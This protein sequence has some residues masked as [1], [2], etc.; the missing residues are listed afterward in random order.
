MSA[1]VTAG[2]EPPPQKLQILC[3]YQG[4]ARMDQFDSQTALGMNSIALSYSLNPRV[5]SPRCFLGLPRLPFLTHTPAS[6]GDAGQN[7]G[8]EKRCVKVGEAAE[9][10]G[11][12]MAGSCLGQLRG[13][14]SSHGASPSYSSSPGPSD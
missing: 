1:L 14:I 6:L 7:Q 11:L 13:E 4:L 10:V 3:V 12:P 5:F 2:R 9:E 8:G